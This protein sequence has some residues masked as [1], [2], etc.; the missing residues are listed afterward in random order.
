MISFSL[1]DTEGAI[2]TEKDLAGTWTVLYFYPKDNTPG[3]T[4]EAM[5]FTALKG[6]FEKLNCRIIGVSP[7]SVKKHEHFCNKHDLSIQLLSDPDHILIDAFDAWKLKKSFGR[8]YMGLV[9]T[10]VLLAPDNEIVKR[11]DNVRVKDH[12]LSV[13]NYLSDIRNKES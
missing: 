13:L 5:N 10:T 11:W 1:P 6:K 8:E 3:C 12:A 9:R 4:T 2:V 7:D